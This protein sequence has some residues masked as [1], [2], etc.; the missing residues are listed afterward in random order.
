MNT[1]GIQ[2]KN[3]QFQKES[4]NSFAEAFLKNSKN[5]TTS[6]EIDFSILDFFFLIPIPMSQEENESRYQLFVV[7]EKGKSS[8]RE[9][10][11]TNNLDVLQKLLERKVKYERM[12]SAFILDL[13]TDKVVSWLFSDEIVTGVY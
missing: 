13:Y 9:G 3:G 1:Y 12:I 4:G 8:K 10:K 11:A 5:K 7:E 2:Y 6:G